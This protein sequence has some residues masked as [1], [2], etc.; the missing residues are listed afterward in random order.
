MNWRLVAAISFGL[1]LGLATLLD[2]GTVYFVNDDAT[3]GNSGGSWPNAWT[4]L[5]SALAAATSG[6]EIRVAQGVYKPGTSPEDSFELVDGVKLLGGFRG[7]N[8]GDANDRN[9]DTFVT[10]L[11]GDLAGDDASCVD[12]SH[13][14]DNA[15]HVIIADGITDSDTLLEGFTITH[16][17]ADRSPNAIFRDYGGGLVNND[18]V[19]YSINECKFTCNRSKNAGGGVANLTNLGP[20]FTNCD[21][22]YNLTGNQWGGG[23]VHQASS[24]STFTSCTFSY[25][26]TDS[27]GLGGAIYA[28]GTDRVICDMCDFEGNTSGTGGA[29]FA[30]GIGIS[31]AYTNCTF[32][33]NEAEA[34]GGAIFQNSVL[35]TSLDSCTFE[36]NLANGGNGGAIYSNVGSPDSDSISI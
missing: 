25:N 11:T 5:Q 6:D 29:I 22:E 26:T 10:I 33:N 27:F 21:F 15:E 8:G 13:L 2:A 7:G 30:E 28:F 19:S 18:V 3:G 16:G 1:F 35:T 4:D 23:A 14:A 36:Q 32:S 20:I 12:D 24:N 17:A 34:D 31:A 9:I